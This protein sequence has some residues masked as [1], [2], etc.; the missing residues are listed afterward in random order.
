[1]ETNLVHSRCGQMKPDELEGTAGKSAR[2]WPQEARVGAGATATN[3]VMTR[4][5]PE[6]PVPGSQGRVG[7]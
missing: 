2:R 1:M 6:N 4:W 5:F 3:V 7:F